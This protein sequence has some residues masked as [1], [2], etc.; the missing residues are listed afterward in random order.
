MA[1]RRQGRV[2]HHRRRLNRWLAAAWRP[3]AGFPSNLAAGIAA[4]GR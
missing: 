4:L 2:D 1:H 3:M